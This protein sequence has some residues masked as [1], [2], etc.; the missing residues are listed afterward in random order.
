MF[1]SHDNCLRRVLFFPC[2]EGMEAKTGVPSSLATERQ[3]CI[4]TIGCSSAQDQIF[5]L[6]LFGTFD[7]QSNFQA[8]QRMLEFVCT[9]DSVKLIVLFF[10]SLKCTFLEV[11]EFLPLKVSGKLLTARHWVLGFLHDT[12]VSHTNHR[13]LWRSMPNSK[14]FGN[15]NCINGISWNTM[16]T[17]EFRSSYFN[18]VSS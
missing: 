1:D 7:L 3:G 13:W 9:S 17:C 4:L 11:K 14:T 12:W 8:F 5:D 2:A 10:P 16:R 6:D 18:N 15:F